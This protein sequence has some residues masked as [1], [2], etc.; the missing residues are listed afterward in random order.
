MSVGF[1]LAPVQSLYRRRIINECAAVGR[2]LSVIFYAAAT[3]DAAA[4]D[5]GV[6]HGP[7]QA[8]VG[9]AVNSTAL[10]VSW[11]APGHHPGAARW[12][13]AYRVVVSPA[14]LDSPARSSSSAPAV[15]TLVPA[16]GGRRT[17]VV[18]VGGLAK[19]TPYTVTVAPVSAGG[20]SGPFSDAI[21]VQ[22]DEDGMARAPA[23]P[24]RPP[25]VVLSP[26]MRV[27][28]YNNCNQL[29]VGATEA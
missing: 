18:V 1:L 25:S 23:C 10:A 17:N 16:A 19:F 26:R 6:P 21:V 27:H 8:V 12:V 7:P 11:Q 3:A 13:A 4:T 24:R 14:S 2:P 5:G 22:T 28:L 15:E 9:S 20:R 29:P